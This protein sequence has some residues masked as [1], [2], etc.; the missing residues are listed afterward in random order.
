MFLGILKKGDKRRA[1][2]STIGLSNSQF[3]R[4]QEGK[5]PKMTKETY[6]LY[7]SSKWWNNRR[8]KYWKHHKRVCYICD[9]YAT[10]LHHNN[11]SRIGKEL[12]KDF[13]PLCNGC[14]KMVHNS[15][16]KLKKAH[17]IL[18]ENHKTI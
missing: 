9:S 3:K 17:I 13:V 8:A 7:L 15:G 10:E 18:K 16:Y 1:S 4:L 5:T 2:S 12:D 6:K 14:H 11:Y